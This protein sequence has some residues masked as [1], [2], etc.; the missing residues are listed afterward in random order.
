M[1]YVSNFFN[2]LLGLTNPIPQ[3]VSIS[4]DPTAGKI[5]VLSKL[6][7]SSSTVSLINGTNDNLTL[8]GLAIQATDIINPGTSQAAIVRETNG[9]AAVEYPVTITGVGTAPATL[10]S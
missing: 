3:P 10:R 9:Y 6:L 4:I 2:K 5:L 8:V 7:G 1:S